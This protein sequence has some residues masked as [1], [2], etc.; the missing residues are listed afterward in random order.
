MDNDEMKIHITEDG[1]MVISG[2][3]GNP[4]EMHTIAIEGKAAEHGLPVAP[5][6][7]EPEDSKTSA[8]TAKTGVKVGAVQTDTRHPYVAIVGGVPMFASSGPVP[9]RV[10]ALL[11]IGVPPEAVQILDVRSGALGIFSAKPPGPHG[12][13][14]K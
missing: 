14:K 4:T 1:Q 7:K 11:L 13:K 9:E 5:A 6:S 3:D 8:S 2:A 10:K 12:G